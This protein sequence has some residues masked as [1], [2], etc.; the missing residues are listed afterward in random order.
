MKVMGNIRRT[1]RQR[2]Q[3]LAEMGFVVL[4]FVVLTLGIIDFGRMLMI[5]NVI[6]HAARDGARIAALTPD[7]SWSGTS[8]TGANATTVQ[9]RVREQIGTI[10]PQSEADAFAV[11][12]SRTASGASVGEEAQVQVVG[13]VPFLFSFPGLWG[14]SIAVDRIAT[15]R[16]EG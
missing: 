4:L 16:F 7:G 6:T 3:A 1:A 10:L 14:G 13:D 2:G 11:N 9:T 5:L 15:Y 8:L 12:I